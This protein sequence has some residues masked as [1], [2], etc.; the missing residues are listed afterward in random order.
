MLIFYASKNRPGKRD[1]V[2]F[3]AEAEALARN[4]PGGMLANPVRAI[5]NSKSMGERLSRVCEA[6]RE[7]PHGGEVAFL[8]HGRRRWLQLVGG[9][10]PAL[11][12]LSAACREGGVQKVCLFACSTGEEAGF[13]TGLAIGID[14]PAVEVYAHEGVGHATRNPRIVAHGATWSAR[15]QDRTRTSLA[16]IRAAIAREPSL[17]FSFMRGLLWDLAATL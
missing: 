17:R 7:M 5:D 8:C 12:K 14:R 1:A 6:I 11:D 9:V 2:L 16:S 13:A 10:G 3:R 4:L 15:L